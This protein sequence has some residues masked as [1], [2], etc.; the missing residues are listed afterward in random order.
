[1]GGGLS[2]NPS[3]GVALGA[4]DFGLGMA[5]VLPSAGGGMAYGAGAAGYN[6]GGGVGSSAGMGVYNSHNGMGLGG[7]VGYGGLSHQAP[8]PPVNP[9]AAG[10]TSGMGGIGLGGASLDPFGSPPPQQQQMAPRQGGVQFN[11]FE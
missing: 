1:M 11:P 2:G 4:L 9:F 3:A 10:G 5:G 8:P 6:S 7:G